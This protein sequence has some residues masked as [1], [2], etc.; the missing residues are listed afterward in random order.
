MFDGRGHVTLTATS[1]FN[2]IVQG[3]ATVR[4][5]Y[6]VM[7]DCTYTSQLENAVTFRAVI[8]NDGDELLILQATPGVVIS[9][10]AKKR[11]QQDRLKDLIQSASCCDASALRGR[12]GFLASGV[13]G[14][15]KG[16]GRSRSTRAVDSRSSLSAVSTAPSTRNP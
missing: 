10:T 1:S 2:G 9:G 3:P 7:E 16:V 8:V 5:T 4:G 13:A 12:Y 6:K 14:P 11:R 15:L